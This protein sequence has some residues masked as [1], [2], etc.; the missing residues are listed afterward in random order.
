MAEHYN[1]LVIAWLFM[2]LIGGWLLVNALIDLGARRIRRWLAERWSAPW[3]RW[4]GRRLGGASA[5]PPTSP[6][7]RDTPR[8]PTV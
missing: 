2:I 7:R 8:M 4:G 5:T 1:M 6:S 3:S